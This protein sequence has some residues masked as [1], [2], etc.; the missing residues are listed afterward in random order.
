VYHRDQVAARAIVVQ[1][2]TP[3]PVQF[4]V[5]PATRYA[6]QAWLALELCRLLGPA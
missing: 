3:R 5:T 1:H 4:Q 2:E 6:V